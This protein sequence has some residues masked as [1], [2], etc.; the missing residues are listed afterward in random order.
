MFVVYV[1]MGLCL[2]GLLLGVVLVDGGG[3]VEGCIIV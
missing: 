1:W 3:G 2:Y